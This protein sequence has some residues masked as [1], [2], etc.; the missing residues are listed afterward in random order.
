VDTPKA[1]QRGTGFADESLQAIVA[2]CDRR[3]AVDL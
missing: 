1:L 3:S 2:S